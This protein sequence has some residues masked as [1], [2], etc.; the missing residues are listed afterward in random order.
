M[1]RVASGRCL[2]SVMSRV[3]ATH[4]WVVCCVLAA[5]W[6]KYIAFVC[7]ARLRRVLAAA[8]LHAASPRSPSVARA[9]RVYPMRIKNI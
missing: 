4:V 3:A 1:S 6:Q 2:L 8:H 9:V 5:S 7:P